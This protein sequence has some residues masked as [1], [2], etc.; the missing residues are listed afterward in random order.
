MRAGL[1]AAR[2][3][4]RRWGPPR[5][6]PP[7]WFFSSSLFQNRHPSPCYRDQDR[8]V[9]RLRVSQGHGPDRQRP[10]RPAG[11][12]EGLSRGL[13]AL[14]RPHSEDEEGL[15]SI[16]AARARAGSCTPPPA[17]PHRLPREG[18]VHPHS[19][20]RRS[21]DLQLKDVFCQ[22]M[23]Y[24]CILIACALPFSSVQSLHAV[25]SLTDSGEGVSV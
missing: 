11:S 9:D 15:P 24:C 6:H 22:K 2:G 3:A 1:P 13:Q 16:S 18:T 4:G 20:V 12:A 14:G 23:K 21:R 17:S 8:R 25:S 19:R 5:N 10:S 7:T